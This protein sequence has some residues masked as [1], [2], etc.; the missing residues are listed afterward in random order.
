MNEQEEFEFRMRLEGEQAKPAPMSKSSALS[1][2]LTDPIQGG[3][4]LLTKMLP[5]SVVQE[6]NRLNNFLADKT[7]LVAKLPEGGVDQ[8]TRERE[9]AY[10][11]QRS[12]AGEKGIDWT[13]LFGNVVNPVNVALAARAPAA[14]SLLGRMGI[15]AG[16]GATT[17]ALAPV[18]DGEFA[19]EK[20]KQMA[21]GGVAGGV[22]PAV[23]AGVGRVISPKAS[24]NPDLQLLKR[25]G[26]FPTVG[27]SLGGRW[28]A[29]EEKLMS[30]PILGDAIANART[31]TLEQFNKAAINRASAGTA[32]AETGHVGVSKAANA[33]GQAYDDAA[34]MVK[35]VQFD[36]QFAHDL[37]QLKQ[38]SKSLLPGMRSKFNDALKDVVGGRTS[39]AGAML[40]DTFKKVDS[41]IGQMARRYSGSSVASEQEL[42]AALTQFQNLLRQQATRV[43]PAYGEA[44]DAANSAYANLVR[45]EGAAKAAKNSGGVFT[46][47]QLNAAIQQAE[48]GVRKRAV[49][50]GKALMQDLG[51]A[52]QNVIG[53]KVPNS[54]TADR[55]LLSAGALGSGVM[56]PWI[57]A[58]L[59]G[60][61]LGYT[62]PA[63]ALLRGLVSSRP[64][65][66]EPIA[67]VLNQ[68]SPVLAPAGGLFGL[69]MLNQ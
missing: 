20:A 21:I 32:V 43:N 12:A 45:V 55:A 26:V 40:P 53:N 48:S 65:L 54:F 19:K 60:G 49:A 30:V 44:L 25:E 56:S 23:A 58:G 66:A 36:A 67:N 64:A 2:G 35:G 16:L 18:T 10:Q 63:Q 17:S 52:G 33:A 41:E 68:T 7:G 5:D 24:T 3:A 11:A 31:R 6:G 57:P 14:V 29:L 51:G 37:G 42:G 50:H 59:V 27:Q 62:P 47:A 13:R 61:A 69:Q 15:G 4:Q 46:P 28:N 1:M 34:S 38:M 9:A 22:V 39:R 8:Q